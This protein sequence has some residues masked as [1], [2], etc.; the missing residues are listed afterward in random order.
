MDGLRLILLLFGL[1]A[2]AGVYLY[3][4]RDRQEPEKK[5]SKKDDVEESPN[6]VRHVPSFGDD[7]DIAPVEEISPE[8]QRSRPVRG[9]TTE[10]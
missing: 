2:V 5:D 7:D 9:G 1:L 8:Q 6:T 4:R 3:S 10:G